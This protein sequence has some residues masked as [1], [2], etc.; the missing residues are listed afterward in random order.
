MLLE[1]RSRIAGNTTTPVVLFL[2]PPACPQ[3]YNARMPVPQHGLSQEIYTR[4]VTPDTLSA[5]M[6]YS[7][8][9]AGAHFVFLSSYIPED[10]FSA[11]SEQYRW[12]ERVSHSA[13]Q[14]AGEG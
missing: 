5:N 6:Y 9:L 14:V 8:D 10:D 12:L 13:L 7:V 2:R 11:S 4:P 1:R 3:A